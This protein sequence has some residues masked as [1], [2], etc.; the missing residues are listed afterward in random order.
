M[1]INILNIAVGQLS[2]V[3]FTLVLVFF[4]VD[5]IRKYSKYNATRYLVEI[6]GICIIL[7]GLLASYYNSKVGVFIINLGLVV[8]VFG[9]FIKA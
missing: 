7:V 4:L 6:L 5:A 2:I 3:V 8:Y 1:Q 9:F